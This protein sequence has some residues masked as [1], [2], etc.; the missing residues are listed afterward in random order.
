VG[1]NITTPWKNPRS[2]LLV[3]TM[4]LGLGALYAIVAYPVTHRWTVIADVALVIAVGGAVLATASRGGV[5]RALAG[6]LA[7]GATVVAGVLL[8]LW[9][10]ILP[11][12]SLVISARQG[13]Y[14]VR[15]RLVSY[16]VPAATAAAIT[17]LVIALRL[18]SG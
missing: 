10:V 12:A 17:A 6:G 14:S 7:M 15:R 5:I 11:L 13:A 3:A 9:I 8:G 2:W 4:L 1:A 16:W 18:A